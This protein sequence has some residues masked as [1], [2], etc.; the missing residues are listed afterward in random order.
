MPTN[1]LL[2]YWPYWLYVNQQFHMLFTDILGRV[3][4]STKQ[5]QNLL[6]YMIHRR[7]WKHIYNL[8]FR[9]VRIFCAKFCYIL[10]WLFIVFCFLLMRHYIHW[11]VQKKV[12]IRIVKNE[13]IMLINRCIQL[14]IELQ[15]GIRFK[16]RWKKLFCLLDE[17]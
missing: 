10:F 14:K 4:I 16:G 2:L 17:M 12:S 7:H 8:L 13:P 11:T 5:Q 3:I 9:I 6:D 1:L 15:W